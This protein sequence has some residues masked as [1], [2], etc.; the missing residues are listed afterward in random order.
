MVVIEQNLFHYMSYYIIFLLLYNFMI[1][2]EPKVVWR[3]IKRRN[4]TF[5][6]MFPHFWPLLCK[7]RKINQQHQNL[8]FVIKTFYRY[9][10]FSLY[11]YYYA[12]LKV[13]FIMTNIRHFPLTPLEKKIVKLL[14][15]KDFLQNILHR[16]FVLLTLHVILVVN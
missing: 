7:H 1:L 3:A 13:I 14:Y 9:Q 10:N 4:C 11:E 2:L 5:S 15:K 6:K 12:Y 8:L 16:K